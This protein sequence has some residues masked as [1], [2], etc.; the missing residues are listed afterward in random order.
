MILERKEKKGGKVNRT[1][2]NKDSPE[3]QIVEA[4]GMK[5]ACTSL[6]AKLGVSFPILTS[7]SLHL[8]CFLDLKG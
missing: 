8:P 2:K 4:G 5:V 1:N 7:A 6:G 3:K